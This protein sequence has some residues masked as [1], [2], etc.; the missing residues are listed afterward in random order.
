VVLLDAPCSG[1]GTMRRHPEIPWRLAPAALDATHP[2]SLPSLQLR[3]VE[4]AATQ[5]APGGRLV[6]AT[7]SVLPQENEAC[8][9]AFL[10]TPAGAAFE[11]LPF[12]ET[13]G[14]KALTAQEQAALQAHLTPAGAFASMPAPGKPDGHYAV[15]IRRKP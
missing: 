2:E 14:F 11:R 5:V 13:P 4:A 8:I 10:A 7:C 6:Y 12:E 3:L 1:T 9:Q 15:C